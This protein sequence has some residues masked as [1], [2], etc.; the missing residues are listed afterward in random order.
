MKLILLLVVIVVVVL[1]WRSV[2]KK[3][4]A[5]VIQ[6]S[7]APAEASTRS[8]TLDERVQPCKVMPCKASNNNFEVS[9]WEDFPS[10][11][12]N[13]HIAVANKASES[14]GFRYVLVSYLV[15]NRITFGSANY[16]DASSMPQTS[17]G[18][19]VQAP[20]MKAE[21]EIRIPPSK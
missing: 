4:D 7:A 6:P 1:V 16:L 5:T 12:P 11:S 2:N 17:Y 9:V 19:N 21:S 13:V 3:G 14:M 10:G 15:D 18:A 20:E 8:T